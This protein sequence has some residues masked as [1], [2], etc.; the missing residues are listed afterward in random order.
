[1]KLAGFLFA[2]LF[3]PIFGFAQSM[4]PQFYDMGSPVLRD[5]WVDPVNGN[6]NHSGNSRAE[7]F[8]TLTH[9]WNVIPTGTML[10]TTGYRIQLVAGSYPEDLVPN[11]WESKYG[12]F[13]NPIILHAVDGAGSAQLP[14]LNI[15]DCSYMYLIGLRIQAGGGDVFHCE[16]C[17]HLLIRQDTITGADPET[18]NVQ[19]TVKV[20][21]SR[22]VY[23]ENSNISGAWD[24]A[25]DF[26]AVQYGHFQGNRIHNAGDWCQYLK[27]GSAY[28][29]VEGNEYFD[30]GTGGFTA[31]QGTGFEFMVSPWLHYESYDIK[32]IN[33]LIHDTEG[34]GMG[35][36]GGYNILMAYNT[37]FRVGSRSH[38]LEFVYGLRS[39]D[40][41][42]SRCQ[43]YL[44]S[45]G[46]GSTG[47]EEPIPNR[48][49][50]VYNNVLYNPPGFQSQWQHLA[51]YGPR[52]TSSGSNIP[53]PARTDTNLRIRG[54]IIW[55]GPSDHPL[56]I[57]DSDQGCRP[58][59]PTC[60]ATQLR[61]DN[62]INTLEPELVDPANGDFRP[63]DSGSVYDAITYD[64]P[65]FPGGDQPQPPIAPAGI[66][67]NLISRDYN[68]N[69][70]SSTNPPGAFASSM[71]PGCS[72]DCE[73][74][75][76]STG[77]LKRKIKFRSNATT[78]GC[79]GAPT[80]EWE[81]GDG[82]LPVFEQNVKHKY[83]MEGDYTW[84]LTASL[85]TA[86]CVRSGTISI[87]R[88]GGTM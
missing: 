70:R 77:K 87:R 25:V 81:F 58:T 16:Q 85:S 4:D 17:D 2:T 28:F 5:V 54:N 30:C 83:P 38:V 9:A 31:G 8:R 41:N 76:P 63:I 11:Y 18:F 33:N 62:E 42:I 12:T 47:G 15:F 10:T 37:L 72:V 40:G 64:I 49:V 29:R 7:A 32:F 56:G 13:Q 43:N 69:P 19:E 60:N 39:C 84:T 59:N 68:G 45:G 57:E 3:M 48:E 24:N 67:Q 51:I 50:F 55:N 26:V 14:A 22:Y 53:S 78:L 75:V 23:V 86:T 44:N 27:G 71:P 6:D 88:K 82:A 74:T 61:S 66:L 20:N 46:W 79:V 36:N 35:V 80:F 34:A 1:M 73:A 21:Q 65:N 52:D